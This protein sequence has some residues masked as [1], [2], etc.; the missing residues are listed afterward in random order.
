VPPKHHYAR[1]R[2]VWR[3]PPR[4]SDVSDVAR[5]RVE[6]LRGEATVEQED[7]GPTRSWPLHGRRNFPVFVLPPSMLCGIEP[8]VQPAA[9]SK[10]TDE[11]VAP[12]LIVSGHA[13]RAGAGDQRGFGAVGGGLAGQRLGD[14]ARA[15]PGDGEPRRALATAKD[16]GNGGAGKHGTYT[17]YDNGRRRGRPW[18][19]DAE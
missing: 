18:A 15:R 3:E 2:S 6:P 17:I 19:A 4:G 13:G 16:H 8:G 10:T 12:W 7:R 14:S 11:N 9:E 5:G 1:V